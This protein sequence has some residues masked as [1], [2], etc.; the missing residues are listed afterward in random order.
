MEEN[1]MTLL[2]LLESL[3]NNV[4]LSVSLADAKGVVLITFNVAGYQSIASELGART[5]T[6]IKIIDPK[7]IM[8]TLADSEENPGG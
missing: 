3:S 8:I 5:V 2:S 6:N 7:T 4:N 1:I